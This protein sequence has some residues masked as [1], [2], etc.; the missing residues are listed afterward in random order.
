MVHPGEEN[1]VAVKLDTRENGE[2][3]PFGFV[4]D[5]LTYG[6][7]YREVWLDVKEKSYIE[8]LY[9]TTPNLTTLK[10]KPAIHNGPRAADDLP[11]RRGT[12]RR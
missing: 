4:I 8:D 7:L 5:Y 3:P 9:I 6:G 1:I 10:I 12:C 11:P 2:V